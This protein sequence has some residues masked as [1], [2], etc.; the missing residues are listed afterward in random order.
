[1]IELKKKKNT[2]THGNQ[3]KK[4]SERDEHTK[5]L[6][7]FSSLLVHHSGGPLLPLLTPPPPY[8]QLY[9]IVPLLRLSLLP[10]SLCVRMNL[11]LLFCSSV[12]CIC[13]IL[14]FIS[15]R[16][17]VR[18]ARSFGRFGWLYGAVA[19][20]APRSHRVYNKSVF[21]LPKVISRDPA[22]D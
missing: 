10:P 7:L 6:T 22:I 14:S 4:G 19:R 18:F 16:D 3:G 11:L 2:P 12:D 17:S 21:V 1:M 13:I 8:I 15:F 20:N 9:A 5:I